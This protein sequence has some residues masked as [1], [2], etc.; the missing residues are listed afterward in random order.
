MT[1][2]SYQP[3]YL[4]QSNGTPAKVFDA[5]MRAYG[6]PPTSQRSRDQRSR[7]RGLHRPRPESTRGDGRQETRSLDGDAVSAHG[8]ETGAH[9]DGVS[10]RGRHGHGARPRRA[11]RRARPRAA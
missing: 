4:T 3:Y 10:A 8:L 6:T 5:I 1:V 11:A 9:A 2:I 7:P